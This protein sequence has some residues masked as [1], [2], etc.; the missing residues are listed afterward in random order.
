MKKINFPL[1]K[2]LLI[3]I[4]SISSVISM[5]QSLKPAIQAKVSVPDISGLCHGQTVLVP[6]YIWGDDILGMDLWLEFDRTIL[7]PGP[8]LGFILPPGSE[9][10]AL[11]NYL[12]PL[13]PSTPVSTLALNNPSLIGRTYNGE[14]VIDLV[15]IYNGSGT[16]ST[17]FHLR[18]AP[19]DSPPP[20]LC[21]MFDSYG[22]DPIPA[23]IFES[24]VISGNSLPTATL[25]GLATICEGESTNLTVNFTGTQPW[26]ITYTD[27]TSSWTIPGITD[28]PYTTLSVSP[29][30]TSTY[31]ITN[32]TDGNGCSNTGAGSATITVNPLPTP[33]VISAGG[34][35]TFCEGGSVVLSGNV[36]GTWNTGAITP[37]I[38]VTASGDYFVTNTNSCGNRESNHI[39]V[40]VNPL[41]TPSVIIAEGPTTFCEGGSVVLSGNVGGT[42]N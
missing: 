2:V 41:P 5:A 27:G 18:S 29:V 24:C 37:D 3:L 33:S 35:T 23:P 32:V 22:V 38:T 16:A 14:K 39:I 17:P 34:P 36:G 9:F 8:G 15:F 7:T 25:S 11:F 10:T 1:A 20:P 19:G 40:T 13:Y 31:T 6:V 4:L 42:W 28:N 21:S 12:N 30:T 26:S